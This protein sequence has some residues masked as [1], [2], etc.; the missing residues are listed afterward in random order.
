MAVGYNNHMNSNYLIINIT[1]FRHMVLQKSL[2]TDKTLKANEENKT[3][4]EKN[5]IFL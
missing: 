1:E 4:D 2:F 3:K 5:I